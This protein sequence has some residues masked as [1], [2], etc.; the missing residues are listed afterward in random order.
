MSRKRRIFDIDVPDMDGIPVGKVPDHVVP[1]RRGPMASAISE[2]ASSLRE[3]QA[4]EDSIRAENDRLATEYVELKRAGMIVDRVALDDIV[5]ERLVRDRK[6]G[7]DDDLAELM[8][9]IRDIGLSNP[10]RLERRADGRFELVQGMRRLLAYRALLA[11]TGSDLYGAIPAGIGAQEAEA[12]VSYRRMVDE[13]L[14][15][16]DISFAEMA[17]LAR[18]YAEDPAHECPEVSEAVAVLFKSASYTKRSYI[19]AFAELLA[20]LDKVLNFPE[21]IP[22]NVGV[23]LKRRMDGDDGLVARVSAALRAA[24]DRD[25]AQEVEILRGFLADAGAAAKAETAG[26][27]A[28]TRQAKTTF[29]VPV[30]SGVAR[31]SASAG[32]LELR[33]DVDF[34]SVDRRSLE[35]AVAAFFAALD[36]E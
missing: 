25:A 34:S 32:R 27:P 26:K 33:H 14:I 8:D 30:D 22:R 29:Q 13:N 5:T 6:P 15:R 12:Q 24:P 23:E 17:M 9:S 4:V 20:R 2:N 16:K 3:R 19:R 11:E 21:D 7:A 10:V 36:E 1:S 31:C 28:R 35:R 18:R